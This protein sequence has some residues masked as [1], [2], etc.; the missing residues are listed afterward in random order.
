MADLDALD[1]AALKALILV[2]HEALVSRQ[3]PAQ[4][5]GESPHM[6]RLPPGGDR[7][8]GRAT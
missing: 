3:A 4:T 7:P 8:A 2:Q 1:P 5:D 6:N